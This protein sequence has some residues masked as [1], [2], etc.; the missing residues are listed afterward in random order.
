MILNKKAALVILI[1]FT[2]GAVGVVLFRVRSQRE[3][4]VTSPTQE[5]SEGLEISIPVE[6]G[7][8]KEINIELKFEGKIKEKTEDRLII[9]DQSGKSQEILINSDTQYFSSEN[10]PQEWASFKTGDLVEILAALTVNSNHLNTFSSNENLPI[11]I[12]A[13][14]V[15]FKIQETQAEKIFNLGAKMASYAGIS[16]TTQRTVLLKTNCLAGVLVTQTIK[17]KIVEFDSQTQKL[18]V[19]NNDTPLEF[20]VLDSAEIFK[21]AEEKSEEG[22]KNL[23]APDIE[24]SVVI[25]EELDLAGYDKSGE[26][27]LINTDNVG[28]VYVL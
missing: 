15:K 21:E 16:V 3:S 28:T 12:S 13:Y 26:P 9:E 14:L 19:K 2:L 23:L 20:I 7:V 17:G 5:S 8:S 1:I 10:E 24:I 18:I 27:F 4:G 6:Q 25:A 22:N 11:A